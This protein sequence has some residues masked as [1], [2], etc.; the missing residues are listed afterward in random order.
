MAR[1]HIDRIGTVLT[2]RTGRRRVLGGFVARGIGAVLDGAVRTGKA[3]TRGTP[4]PTEDHYVYFGWLLATIDS[5]KVE[6][7]ATR[8]VINQTWFTPTL[9]GG[10]NAALASD[11]ALTT[12]PRL[13][14]IPSGVV[15]S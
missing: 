2:G 5:G 11:P 12:D 3:A 15:A 7:L 9:I 4:S 6:A 10:R 1:Q 14:Y 8:F 13:R